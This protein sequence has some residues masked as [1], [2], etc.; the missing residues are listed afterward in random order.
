[1]GLYGTLDAYGY[2]ATANRLGFGFTS[3]TNSYP[4]LL[5]DIT[6]PEVMR[7]VFPNN[8]MNVIV[9]TGFD[10]LKVSNCSAEAVIPMPAPRAKR[11]LQ[12]MQQYDKR[13]TYTSQGAIQITLK[14]TTACG[15]PDQWQYPQIYC[16]V[17]TRGRWFHIWPL[18]TQTVQT[19]PGVFIATCQFLD[20]ADTTNNSP[21]CLL[22]YPLLDKLCTINGVIQL[23]GLPIGAI[24]LAFI[25]DPLLIEL[26][27]PCLA[28]MES[29]SN[30]C[31]IQD[32]YN[33][34]ELGTG[35]NDMFCGP[36][37]DSTD[38]KVV[39]GSSSLFVPAYNLGTQNSASSHDIFF[40][41]PNPAPPG[42]TCSPC[43]ANNQVLTMN[44]VQVYSG[45]FWLKQAYGCDSKVYYRAVPQVESFQAVQAFC[46]MTAEEN[47]QFVDPFLAISHCCRCYG[48]DC[49]CG[50]LL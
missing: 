29:L 5:I 26:Y 25:L 50:G 9:D 1:M 24:C 21:G 10:K 42:A 48:V 47:L 49:G 15:N 40:D 13:D 35:L 11:E 44:W 34:G 37:P 28:A 41:V 4:D 36:T 23:N 30:Y 3:D 46:Q 18:P 17:A 14:Y 31:T 27:F 45:G 7:A 38:L 12:T 2:P 43:T 8:G 16:H 33:G 6:N 22:L 20:T 39:V 32:T 19:S